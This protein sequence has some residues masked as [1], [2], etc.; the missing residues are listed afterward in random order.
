MKLSIS[1]GVPG[2]RTPAAFLPSVE[3]FVSHPIGLDERRMKLVEAADKE[4]ADETIE[5]ACVV[6]EQDAETV[7]QALA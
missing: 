2:K 3:Q 5:E 6:S 7:V 1:H 4:V